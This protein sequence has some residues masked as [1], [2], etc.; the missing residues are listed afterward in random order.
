MGVENAGYVNE[1][2]PDAPLGTESISEGDNHIRVIK[3]ALV[4]SFPK[5]SSPVTATPADLNAV[6]QM[7]TD[8]SGALSD[9]NTIKGKPNGNVASCYYKGGSRL[10]EYNVSSVTKTPGNNLGTRITFRNALQG[11]TPSH[12]SFSITPVSVGGYPTTIH[13]TNVEQAYIDFVALEFQNTAGDW[14]F[15]EGTTADFSLIVIDME[16]GQ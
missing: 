6:S 15:M 10:Y 12:Y 5:I 1:L 8:L 9:I 11:P 3:N 16:A 2:D 13:V 14:V 4:K 7:R